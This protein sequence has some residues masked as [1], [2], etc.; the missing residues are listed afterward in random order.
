MLSLGAFNKIVASLQV[1]YM[2]AGISIVI[3]C[4]YFLLSS[5][6]SMLNPAGLEIGGITEGAL[7]IISSIFA[8]LAI[9]FRKKGFFAVYGIL[10][11]VILVLASAGYSQMQIKSRKAYTQEIFS[12]MWD[13]LPT[14][15]VLQ[16]QAYGECCGFE[17]YADRIQEPCKKYREQ[18]GCYE[19]MEGYWLF[20]INR[21]IVP[22]VIVMIACLIEAVFMIVLFMAV[23]KKKEADKRKLI[24]DRQPFDAW[25]KAVFN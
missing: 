13:R 14:N 15:S 16:I 9:I 12:R 10:I 7:M 23:R 22:T 19:M 6:L 2:F 1:V 4:L 3:T 25:H 18:V 5:E 8:L 24:T 20:Q 11:G 21:L 17:A